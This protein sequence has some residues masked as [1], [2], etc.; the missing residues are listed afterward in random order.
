MQDSFQV[1]TFDK[2]YSFLDFD[3][4]IDH[5][6]KYLTNYASQD[7]K[8]Y[9]A[10]VFVCISKNDNAKK[11]VGYYTLSSSYIDISSLGESYTK[12][13]PRYPYFPAVLIG[14][15]AVDK[16][17]QGKGM[18]YWL[19]TD[20]LYKALK[21]EI[22]AFGVVVE[23][24]NDKAASFYKNYKFDKCVGNTSKLFLRMSIIAEMFK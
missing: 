14:R 4:G 21:S 15:L 8:R 19:L 16:N 20:G 13:L 22:A 10:S 2:S 5:L 18:G 7:I 11:V 23:A 12:K 9:L 17:H 24:K 6:N 1:I 3:C